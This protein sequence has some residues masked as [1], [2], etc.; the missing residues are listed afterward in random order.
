MNRRIKKKKAKQQQVR[1]LAAC[2]LVM[3]YLSRHLDVY[4]IDDEPYDYFIMLSKCWQNRY[5]TE[6]ENRPD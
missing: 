3:S 6:K 5:G 4:Q 1:E 2:M